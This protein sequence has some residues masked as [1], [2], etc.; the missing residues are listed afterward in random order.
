MSADEAHRE[1]KKRRME[2][3]AQLDEEYLIMEDN[4]RRIHKRTK[5]MQ[6]EIE[7][8][9]QEKVMLQVER[10]RDAM[11]AEIEVSRVLPPAHA[12]QDTDGAV[13]AF[14]ESVKA[15]VV[16][17]GTSVNDQAVNGHAT[18]NGHAPVNGKAS[19][20]NGNT[21]TNG[22]FLTNG[23]SH[24]NR[25]S[26]QPELEVRA[27]PPPVERGRTPK[28]A[29]P[30]P[31]SRRAKARKAKG[32]VKPELSPAPAARDK[33]ASP[34]SAS[35]G[36]SPFEPDYSSSEGSGSEDHNGANAGSDVDMEDSAPPPPRTPKTPKTP[37]QT[38]RRMSLAP[39][40]PPDPRIPLYRA[41]DVRECM[42]FISDMEA[43]F[44]KFPLY[45]TDAHK[46]ELGARYLA[47]ELKENWHDHL[48]RGKYGASWSSYRTFLAHQLKREASPHTAERLFTESKQILKQSITEFGLWL[49]QWEP[50]LSDQLTDL[51]L[52]V[53]LRR[54]AC[55]AIREKATRD[56]ED[57][58]DYYAFIEYLQRVEDSI[59]ERTAKLGRPITNNVKTASASASDA[60][61]NEH[62][63]PSPPPPQA[64]RYVSP[65]KGPRSQSRPK[66]SPVPPEPHLK[67]YEGKSWWECRNLLS[68][69]DAQF[70]KYPAYYTED[71]KVLCGKRYLSPDL[72]NKWNA[73]A[74]R[75]SRVPWLAFCTF[76]SQQLP[77][78]I[79]QEKARAIY[80]KAEQ[81][82][83]QSV[84]I[85]SLSMLR[86]APYFN[87]RGHNRLR[88]L[89]DH[90]LPAIR[91]ASQKTWRDF[92]DF[93]EF[94]AY[95]QEV[96]NSLQ[97]PMPAMGGAKGV[98]RK[99]G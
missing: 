82:P 36:D 37:M 21:N 58:E 76:V 61:S 2:E 14:I 20:T 41:R 31:E 34:S 59:P 93:H 40:I 70:S 25:A 99:R 55:P 38:S 56:L 46:V 5:L 75:L 50:H 3:E 97:G 4:L 78:D 74:N 86:Y 44:A 47:A 54:G 68:N 71:G 12:V 6:L 1:A 79:P 30:T 28:P 96:Q 10:E 32:V 81:K 26:P 83:S 84:T 29:N 87:P 7:V 22:Q 60:G 62:Q 9:R 51:Q 52:R 43:H 24:R 45:Y 69:L 63:T 16:P 17:N 23:N 19:T 67:P 77:C 95:L 39:S 89:W 33:P 91:S 92:E 98:P 35:G 94:V 72:L 13:S 53:L 42:L 27:G 57:F 48:V 88:H 15:S 85:F 66:L 65:P 18:Q 49:L 80:Q 73:Y 11:L 64:P 90:T 8:K